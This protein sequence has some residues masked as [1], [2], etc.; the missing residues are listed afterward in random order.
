MSDTE[1][2]SSPIDNDLVGLLLAASK[3]FPRDSLHVKRHIEE[4]GRSCTVEVSVERSQVT[5]E[6]SAK[7]LQDVLDRVRRAGLRA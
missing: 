7:K 3:V 4:N 6:V 2:T 1:I 5:V